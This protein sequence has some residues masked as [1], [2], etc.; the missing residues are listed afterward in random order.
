MSE[1]VCV[2]PVRDD[3]KIDQVVDG[4]C[5]LS[6]FNHLDCTEALKAFTEVGFCN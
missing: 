6:A 1:L 3:G 2:K 4:C 5:N